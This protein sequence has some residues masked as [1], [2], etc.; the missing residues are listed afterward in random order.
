[1]YLHPHTQVVV[2]G[3]GARAEQLEAA[4][5]KHL[6]FNQSILHLQE[7]EAVPQMLPPAL[8]ETIP[9]LPA[10][11]KGHTVAVICSGFSCKPPI[12]EPEELKKML[13]AA[14]SR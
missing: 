13:C 5:L 7:G 12:S 14:D 8:A 4:A 9:N 6:S 11:K 1:M 2:V 10:I 3:S